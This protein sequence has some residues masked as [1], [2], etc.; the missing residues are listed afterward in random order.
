MVPWL[1]IYF[2][3]SELIQ[4]EFLNKESCYEEMMKIPGSSC[5][6]KPISIEVIGMSNPSIKKG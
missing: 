4:E 5:I 2:I 3:K 6:L 1:L